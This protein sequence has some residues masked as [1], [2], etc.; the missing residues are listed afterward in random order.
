MDGCDCLRRE[1]QASTVPP[2]VLP[3]VPPSAPRGSAKHAQYRPHFHR[4]FRPQFRPQFH[5]Q[6]HRPCP[7]FPPRSAKRGQF[8]SVPPSKTSSASSTKDRE[9]MLG[10][11]D[12]LQTRS[13]GDYVSRRGHRQDEGVGSMQHAWRYCSPPVR[14]RVNA[15]AA[16]W[17]KRLRTI[18]AG[19]L[20]GAAQL[21]RLRGD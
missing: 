7:E 10:R 17:V 4:Q 18:T 5:L 11:P 3:T 13:L 8:R 20:R 12:D 14:A 19:W 2:T 1:G 16:R 21:E 9:K 6:F 15:G